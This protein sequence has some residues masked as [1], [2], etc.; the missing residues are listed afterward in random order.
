[1]QRVV[2]FVALECE[3]VRVNHGFHKTRNGTSIPCLPGANQRNETVH[4]GIIDIDEVTRTDYV[5]LVENRSQLGSKPL[6]SKQTKRLA[7]YSRLRARKQA[8]A[9]TRWG[10]TGQ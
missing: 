9:I 7:G 5:E 2:F 8:A 10:D 1:M 3:A 6:V 4:V